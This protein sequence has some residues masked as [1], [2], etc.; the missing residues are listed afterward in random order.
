[1][2]SFPDLTADILRKAP[3]LRG[4]LQANAPLGAMSWF[5]T[6][7]VAQLLFS[8]ADTEDLA[9]FFK[10]LDTDMPV[11]ILGAGSNM[12][13]RDGG[14]AGAV[15][16]IGKP[17]AQVSTEE[18]YRIR[19]GAAAPDVKVA[20]AAAEAGIA[21]L[22]FLRGIPGSIGGAVRMNGGSYGGEVSDVFISL[23]GV[24]REGD[25]VEL[26]KDNMKFAYRFCGAPD[27]IVFTEIL[28]Q[29]KSGNREEILQDMNEITEKRSQTQPVNAK[30]AGSTFKN[31][32]NAK[33]WELIEA[34]GCRGLQ[35]GD[36]QMSEKHCNFM[37]NLGNATATDLENLGEEV[38]RRVKE[39]SGI[40]L[41]WEVR[42]IGQPVTDQPSP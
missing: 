33:A 5:R 28:F 39:H 38:R 35:V 32:P 37:I 42:R 27:N 11:L 9:C 24:T 40:E 41:E 4:D 10:A 2:M 20:R 15:V 36:A 18:N 23:R 13:V 22:S 3:D 34:A 19:A 25:L 16:Q 31:P 14:V 12:L 21:G 26:S 29:G 6:G 17:F 7:G 30:T 8:P 1:M